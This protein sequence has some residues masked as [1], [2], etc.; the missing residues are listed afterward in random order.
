L[1]KSGQANEVWKKYMGTDLSSREMGTALTALKKLIIP[2]VHLSH[3]Q[4]PSEA[5][6]QN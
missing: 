6:L 2:R 4:F 3:F 5:R 1:L